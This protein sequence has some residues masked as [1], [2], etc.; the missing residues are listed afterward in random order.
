VKLPP[1][2]PEALGD[3]LLRHADGDVRG[4]GGLRRLVKPALVFHRLQRVLHLPDLIQ[5]NLPLV[6]EHLQPGV[7]GVVS[8]HGQ[9]DVLPDV[10]DGHTGLFHAPD[11]LQPLK[12]RFPEHPNAT[13]GALH[14]G[15]QPLL[16]IVAQRGCRD[17]QQLRHFTH[18]IDHFP[19]PPKKFCKTP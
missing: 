11:D 5:Q 1:D 7:D 13:G 10:T 9:L 14:K 17:I 6:V 19:I 16:V 18:G 3:L 15:Q 4:A 8:L 2:G 12:V